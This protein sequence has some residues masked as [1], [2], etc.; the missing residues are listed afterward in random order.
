MAKNNREEGHYNT[1]SILAF[2]FAFIFFPVGFVLGIISLSQIKKTN[3]H[4]QGLAIAAIVISALSFVFLVLFFIFWVLLISFATNETLMG[5]NEKC[6]SVQVNPVEV[7]KTM[8]GVFDV[9]LSR[10]AG[11]EYIN[12]GGVKLVFTN[13]ENTNNYFYDAP[14]DIFEETIRI[15]IPEE[16]L[17]NPNKVTAVV[18]FL[19]ESGN[20][21][22]CPNAGSLEF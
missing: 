2:V 9:T 10:Q 4:G 5:L 17:E 1:F 11:G 13:A 14:G 12:I 21:E 15:S 18:Y 22:I 3:E 19:D 6:I 16:E 7:S 8:P 20:P